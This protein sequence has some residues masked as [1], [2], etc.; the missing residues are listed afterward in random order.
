V[1]DVGRRHGKE[2]NGSGAEAAPV[3]ARCGLDRRP[4]AP[5]GRRPSR[6]VCPAGGEAGGNRRALAEALP[7]PAEAGAASSPDPLGSTG[8]GVRRDSSTARHS[9]EMPA[10]WRGLSPRPDP[11][12]RGVAEVR[13]ASAVQ[14]G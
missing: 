10:A 1:R 11:R 13:R 14:W 5:D 12:V 2:Q 9:C 6:P 8:S 3:G 4:R 7:S